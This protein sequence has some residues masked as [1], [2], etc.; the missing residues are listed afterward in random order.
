MSTDSPLVQAATVLTGRSGA[1]FVAVAAMISIYGTIALGILFALRVAYAFSA[2]GDFP[3]CLTR[4]HPRFNTPVLAI[5][6]FS[7]I[8]WLMALSGTFLLLA[9]L[10]AGAVAIQYGA[11]CAALIRLRR[12][13]P[14]ASALRLSWDPRLPYLGLR[15]VSC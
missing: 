5:V 8:A 13:Q 11:I 9:A 6:I 3:P 15:F 14:N 7:A 2:H 12:I 1:A 4:L 10:T